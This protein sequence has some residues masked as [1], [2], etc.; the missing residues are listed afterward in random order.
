MKQDSL[1]NLLVDSF[2]NMEGLEHLTLVDDY[3]FIKEEPEDSEGGSRAKAL[4]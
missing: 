3:F 4:N 2:I 1:F